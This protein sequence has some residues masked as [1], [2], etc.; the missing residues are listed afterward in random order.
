MDCGQEGFFFNA[1][2]AQ[3]IL[4]IVAA[5]ISM[6]IPTVVRSAIAIPNA[7]IGII[8]ML[9]PKLIANKETPAVFLRQVLLSKYP[10]K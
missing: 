4:I 9:M 1:M 5:I 6:L 3:A 8:A 2:A 10:G 7:A